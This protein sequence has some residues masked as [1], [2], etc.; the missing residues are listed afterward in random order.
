MEDL[1]LFFLLDLCSESWLLLA[2]LPSADRLGA[3]SEWG[4]GLCCA[5]SSK[6]SFS[7]QRF[8]V[9]DLRNSR[10]SSSMAP[11]WVRV[12]LSKRSAR[13]EEEG[14]ESRSARARSSSL[15]FCRVE[16]TQVFQRNPGDLGN[17]AEPRL[18]ERPVW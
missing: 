3:E 15:L 14:A 8:P 7:E 1:M 6:G 12:I 17:G 18:G 16:K 10:A 2:A 13:V 5:H 9:S 4:R 11:G